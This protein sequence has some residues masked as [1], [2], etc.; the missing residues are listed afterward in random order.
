VARPRATSEVSPGGPPVRFGT[1]PFIPPPPIC[2]ARRFH[3]PGSTTLKL[4]GR[5][6]GAVSIGVMLPLTR[7]CAGTLFVASTQD[8]SANV[9]ALTR[10][11]MA[12]GSIDTPTLAAVHSAA[13]TRISA[14]SA[15]AA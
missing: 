3:D 9:T 10:S 12:D 14:A 2:A 8:G 1:T 15:S 5:E 6:V 4:I 11:P 7:Q 13:V